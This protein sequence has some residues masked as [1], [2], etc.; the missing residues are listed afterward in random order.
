MSGSKIL[1]GVAAVAVGIGSIAAAAAGPVVTSRPRVMDAR[2]VPT[3][4]TLSSEDLARLPGARDAK[5]ILD[6]HNQL[7][8]EVGAAPLRW[9]PELATGAAAYAPVLSRIGALQH[10]PR[11]GR[12]IV[13]ENLLQSFRGTPMR[14]MMQVWG[15]E[16]RLFVPG[17]FP[18]VSRDGNWVSVAHYSQMIWPTTREVGC[19]IASDARFNWLVCR[20]SPGGNKDGV[21]VGAGAL[22]RRQER[23]R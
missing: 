7:R 16:R 4:N 13:R 5:T 11:V 8:A 6:Y 20:Y 10:A 21:L 17:F 23:P 14:Q 19:G 9:S 18:N 22:P 12:G 2:A 1:A 3:I 15:N